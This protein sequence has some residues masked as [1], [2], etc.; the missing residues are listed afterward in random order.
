[1]GKYDV[2]GGKLIIL[3]SGNK[4]IEYNLAINGDKLSLT[5]GALEPKELELTRAAAEPD[6]GPPGDTPQ[7]DGATHPR[8]A[9]ESGEREKN[10]R[11][12]RSSYEAAQ[13][14]IVWLLEA[15]ETLAQVGLYEARCYDA[16]GVRIETVRMTF[17]PTEVEKGERT[18]ATLV[19]PAAE[20]L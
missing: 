18:R 16:D 8:N 2:V 11:V 14:Q 1:E 9:P 15:K 19:L 6:D 4:R 20:A 3:V 17:K 10:F 7:A 13:N 12:V 5:G